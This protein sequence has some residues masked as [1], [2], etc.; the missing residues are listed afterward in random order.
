MNDSLK[1]TIAQINPTVGA[2]KANCQ[3]MMDSV[4]QAPADTDIV[5][6]PELSLCAYPPEDLLFRDDF[7][8]QCEQ[9]LAWLVKQSEAYSC[10]LVVGHPQREEGL[11]YNAMSV[12]RTGQVLATYYKRFLPNYT[13]FDEKRYFSPGNKA[14]IVE[15]NGVKCGLVICEDI[16]EEPPVKES[17][18]LGAQLILNI[19]ASPFHYNKSIEREEGIVSRRA[20]ENNVP[21]VYVNQMGG[22]DELVFDGASHIVNAE[23]KIT[24]RLPIFESCVETS[25]ITVIRTKACEPTLG[26]IAPRGTLNERIY[27]ALVTGVKDYVNKNGF[28]RVIL[29]LSGGIDSGLTLAIAVDALGA[30]RVEAVMMPYHYTSEMSLSDAE[31]EAAALGVKY[32]VVSIAPIVEASLQ[33]LGPMFEGMEEDTTEENIQARSR[34]LILMAISNK[35]GAMVLTTGNKS[36]MA[37]GY[38]TLYGDMAGGFAAIKD[39]PK[40]RVFELSKYRNTLSQVI[41]ERVITRPPSAELR[42]DQEDQDSLPEYSILDSI[43]KRFVELDES[44]E[45]IIEQG[46]DPD[47][48]NQVIKMVVR[49]EYKRRQ[50]APGVRITPR[51]FGRDRRYPITAK[52][53]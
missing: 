11:L 30:D 20:I 44:A 37:V 45:K 6:F 36:E 2:L 34:M 12:I 49:N 17:V 48:V 15:I 22:Q 23:G 13:V 18:A 16:W 52:F 40:T 42:P 4:Q 47:T 32:H 31:E 3:L 14:Q 33:Q 5:V 53:F 27:S 43:L 39:V 8:A 21:I 19:N 50:S 29:G 46:F 1:L 24:T 7:I 10:A 26:A 35:T 51:A 9:Q 41:P 38:A 28:K 25:Q